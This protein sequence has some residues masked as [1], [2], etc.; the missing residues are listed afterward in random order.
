MGTQY[1]GAMSSEALVRDDLAAVYRICHALNLNEGT[2]PLPYLAHVA[3]VC[4]HLSAAVPGQPD[5][6]LAPWSSLLRPFKAPIGLAEVIPYGLLWCEVTPQN[7][8][9]IDGEGGLS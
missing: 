9:V 5:R 1:T 4:N 3:G 6:F 8:V 2:A 7:L